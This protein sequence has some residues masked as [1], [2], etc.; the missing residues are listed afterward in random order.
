MSGNNISGTIPAPLPSG[1]FL[2]Y[3][4]IDNCTY[5]RQ[6]WCSPSVAPS[7]LAALQDVGASLSFAYQ[8][9]WGM[10]D[11][12]GASWPGVGCLAP[13]GDMCS[14]PN[15]VSLYLQGAVGT[16]PAA[17]SALTS[18]SSLQVQGLDVSGPVPESW[19]SLS[20]LE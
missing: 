9:L 6:P 14:P 8:N 2:D 5:H 7:T 4:C 16:L 17:V 12:C 1:V 13:A 15:V 3:N 20:A 11:P 10:G 18:L 19:A